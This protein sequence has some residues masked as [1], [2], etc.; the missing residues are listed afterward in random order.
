MRAIYFGNKHLKGY[1]GIADLL[2]NGFYWFTSHE[3]DSIRVH[4]S[5]LSF[6]VH[7]VVF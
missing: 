6:L 7:P 3:G 1:E 2:G 4:D 5:E